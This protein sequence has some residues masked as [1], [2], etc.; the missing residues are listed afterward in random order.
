VLSPDFHNDVTALIPIMVLTK[1]TDRHRRQSSAN[2]RDHSPGLHRIFIAIAVL[3]EAFALAGAANPGDRWT[4]V[5]VVVTLAACA[6]VFTAEL[7]RAD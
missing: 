5:I 4:D 7:V 2:V 3:G 6:I 1:V